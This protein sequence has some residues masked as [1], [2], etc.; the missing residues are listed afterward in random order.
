[1]AVDL[2]ALATPLEPVRLPNG[3]EHA[4]VPLDAVGWQLLRAVQEERDD[5]KAV[6]L[7]RRCLPTASDRD[8]E[9]LGIEDVGTLLVYAARKVQLASDA[10][11]NSRGGTAP[12]TPASV[13][14]TTSS[15]SAPGS[16]SGTD[17][18]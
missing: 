12:S 17:N 2:L 16:P 14:P 10:V 1:M 8:L 11:G 15:T 4:V 6:A 13:P 5:A 9:S 3:S 7:L 18:P